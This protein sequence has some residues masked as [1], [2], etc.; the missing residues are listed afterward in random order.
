[1]DDE[2]IKQLVDAKVGVFWKAMEGGP[3]KRGQVRL[4]SLSLQ[5]VVLTAF[6]QITITFSEKRP[7]KTWFIID[8]EV[9]NRLSG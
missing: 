4:C 3:H 9:W 2:D 6:S 5:P 7:R 8:G 1:M